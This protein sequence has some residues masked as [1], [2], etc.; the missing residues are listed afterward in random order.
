MGL[1]AGMMSLFLP[2]TLYY[3]IPQTVEQAE[4]WKEDY[5]WPCRKCRQEENT[6]KVDEESIKMM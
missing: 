6:Y 2:E 4:A 3:P 1:T 5:R